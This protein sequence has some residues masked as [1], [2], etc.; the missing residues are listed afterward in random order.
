MLYLGCAVWAY[1]GWFG[2]FY[3]A[4]LP[5]RESL[6]AYAQRLTA[7]EGNTT[8]YAVPSGETV[9]RWR[10]ETPPEF[11]FCVKF[12]RAVS[13]QG[14]LVPRLD[15][16]QDFLDRLLPLGERLG[17]V[18]LQLPPLYGPENLGDLLGFFEGLAGYS[19]PLAVEVRHPQWWQPEHQ[20][21]LHQALGAP[22]SGS[23]RDRRLSQ[24]ILDTR[25]IYQCTDDPQRY[26]KRRKPKLPVTFHQTATPLI[27]RFISHPEWRWNEAYLAEW[28]RFLESILQQGQ[29]VYFFVHCPT[30][31]HSP[32][33][34]RR[35]YHQLQQANLVQE[36]LPWD[37]LTSVPQQ[38]SLF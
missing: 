34:A 25:P 38:L 26:A 20:S 19:V 35:F 7:I 36:P 31:E 22:R 2:N 28:Q 18:F 37:S 23:L 24:V 8:F 12:P 29:T 17:A 9:Q 11:R 33:T 13:H 10:V 15:K 32:F 5:K 16:A 30:E 27:V 1:E 21:I 6:R 4:D 3:P 14:L